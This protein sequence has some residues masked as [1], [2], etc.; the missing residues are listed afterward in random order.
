MD[1][2]RYAETSLP[3]C[4]MACSPYP[5][6]SRGRASTQRQHSTLC[7]RSARLTDTSRHRDDDGIRR[8]VGRTRR[9]RRES[10]E[11]RLLAQTPERTGAGHSG[12]ET[13]K[14]KE[15]KSQYH[16]CRAFS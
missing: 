7:P 4:L 13:G 14:E 11:C 12:K 1:L 5:T 16:R 10:R 15:R 6:D 9:P 8:G 2:L 3:A